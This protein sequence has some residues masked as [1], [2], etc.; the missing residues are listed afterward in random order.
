MKKILL[1]LLAVISFTSCVQAQQNEK[2]VPYIEVTGT[3]ELE[4]LPNEIYIDITVD[5]KDYDGD[6]T[7]ADI[8]KSMFALFKKQNI[9]IEKQFSV[10]D[11]INDI[12]KYWLKSDATLTAK[13]YQLIAKS[14]EQTNAIFKGL[15]ELGISDVTIAKLEHSDIDKLKLQVKVDAIKKAKEKAKMLTNAIN[16]DIGTA[17]FI[18][19]Q[20]NNFYG[21]E[22]RFMSASYSF[23]LKGA[24]SLA[25]QKE[26][27]PE[28]QFDKIRINSTIYVRFEIK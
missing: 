2:D 27:A 17:L 15:K 11:M 20:G 8:E 22:V 4:V 24:D 16:Q 1:T 18:Q 12:Q 19:E 3:G 10:K 25:L 23:G 7:I 26:K 21:G 28:L 6:K 14:A 5:E 9:D 13:R